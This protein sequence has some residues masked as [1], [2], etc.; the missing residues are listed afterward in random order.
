MIDCHSLWSVRSQVV[1]ASDKWSNCVNFSAQ[2]NMLECVCECV[3]VWVGLRIFPGAR[4]ERLKLA[5]VSSLSFTHTQ[6]LLLQDFLLFLHFL[7]SLSFSLC[8]SGVNVCILLKLWVK[9]SFTLCLR[10][11]WTASACVWVSFTLCVCLCVFIS[12]VL[13]TKF[14]NL[15]KPS[16]KTPSKV[17]IIY[18]S[19]YYILN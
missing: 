11:S 15:I 17:K 5:Q 6:S 16:L 19:I 14:S 4:Q 18:Q 3:C 9:Q 8:L 13:G 12:C 7:L 2:G 1:S 10:A